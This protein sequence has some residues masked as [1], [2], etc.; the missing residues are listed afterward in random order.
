MVQLRQSLL[1]GRWEEHYWQIVL[2]NVVMFRRKISKDCRRASSPMLLEKEISWR[3]D[4]CCM[5]NEPLIDENIWRNRF[6]FNHKNQ[7]TK[8]CL[9]PLVPTDLKHVFILGQFL[10]IK[11]S[12]TLPHVVFHISRLRFL[13][14]EKEAL[15]IIRDTRNLGKR[16]EKNVPR[17]VYARWIKDFFLMAFEWYM[18]TIHVHANNC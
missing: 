3:I 5:N 15:K 18:E 6:L 14:W 1:G 17:Y 4:N 11:K 12:Q 13:I 7:Q 16:R 8:L 10:N 2:Q 9:S